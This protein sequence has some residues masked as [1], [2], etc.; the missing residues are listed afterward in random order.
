MRKSLFLLLIIICSCENKPQVFLDLFSNNISKKIVIQE[1]PTDSLSMPEA[2]LSDGDY[3][4]FLEPSL[5]QLLTFYDC[6]KKTFSHGLN[7]GQGADEAISVQTIGSAK[8]KGEIYA[9]DLANQSVFLL[10]L[11][12]SIKKVRKDSINI[13]ARFCEV[14]YDDELAFFLLVGDEKRFLMKA[15]GQLNKVGENIIIPDISSE[16]VS[17]TLQGPCT[18]SSKN[19]RIAWFSVYGDVMEIYDYSNLSNITLVQSHVCS[20]PIFNGND[21]ALNF[22]TKLSVSSVTSDNNYI[23]ALYNERSLEQAAQ[24]RAQAFF[25]KKI[26]LFDWN[27][28]PRFI[29]EL[30]RPVKSITCDKKRNMILCLGLNDDLEF[31]VFGF[32]IDM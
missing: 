25:S 32:P 15:N 17:Q 11:D 16:I 10:S 24:N 22:K 12:D 4:V 18:I 2:I 5:P 28:N 26:L 31:A 19:K 21:G 8:N 23:Y 29:V 7:K 13:V 30:D 27:G 14:A 1:I 3:L 6:E 9:S 20:L